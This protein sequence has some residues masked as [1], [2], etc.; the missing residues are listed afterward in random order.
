MRKS[1]RL[2]GRTILI[3]GA[4]VATAATM[5]RGRRDTFRP[6]LSAM[7]IWTTTGIGAPILLT[8][9][10]GIRTCQKD[11]RLSVKGTG[12]GWIHGDG[13]GWTTNP[14]AMLPFTTA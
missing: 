13:L 5:I 2:A 6:M 3:T 12:P 1:K 4:T 7:K 9:M 8:A 14:G 11:G 10:S